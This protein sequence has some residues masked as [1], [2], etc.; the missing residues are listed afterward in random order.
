MYQVE[1]QVQTLRVPDWI[2]RYCQPERFVLAVQCMSAVR[3]KLGLSAGMPQVERIAGA[4]SF[5]QVIGAE[6][7]L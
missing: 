1:V 6:G 4:Y 7:S 5:V 3:K 2:S